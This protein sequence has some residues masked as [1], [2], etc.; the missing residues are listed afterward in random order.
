MIALVLL[1]PFYAVIGLFV[2]GHQY[3]N[4]Y[5]SGSVATRH[6]VFWPLYFVRWLVANFVLA[7]R[8]L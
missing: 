8:G 6:A 3:L 5:A 1:I 2:H 4:L 7:I